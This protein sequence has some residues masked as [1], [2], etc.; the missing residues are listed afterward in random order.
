MDALGPLLEKAGTSQKSEVVVAADVLLQSAP[1]AETGEPDKPSE[2]EVESKSSPKVTIVTEIEEEMTEDKPPPKPPTPLPS[3]DGILMNEEIAN[4]V[5]PVFQASIATKR[6]ALAEVVLDCLQLMIAH[7]CI[8]GVVTTV[9]TSLKPELSGSGY[10]EGLTK[11]PGRVPY[12]GQIIDMICQCED[13][14]E[15]GVEL[16]VLKALLTAVTS[17]TFC[18]HGHG[19]LLAV[20]TSYNIYLMSR[21]P[22][23]QTTAKA[24]L[25]QMLNVVFQ[26]ME[27]NSQHI[28]VSPIIVKDVIDP[29]PAPGSVDPS[30]VQTFLNKV[31]AETLFA[32][33]L[34]DLRQSVAGAFDR[35]HD[36]EGMDTSTDSDQEHIEWRKSEAIAV[37]SVK[38]PEQQPI[39]PIVETGPSRP[40]ER[41]ASAESDIRSSVL[42]K[43]AY[44]VF[45]AL[46]KLSTTSENTALDQA[47]IRGKV[48]ALELIKILLEN[49]GP[50]FH[51]S[52]KFISALKDNLCL[53]MLKNCSSSIQ[54]VLSLTCSIFL[55][56]L[57]K[58]RRSLKAEI[59]V[60][61]PMVVLKPIEPQVGGGSTTTTTPPSSTSTSTSYPHQVK[62]EF[63]DRIQRIVGAC[64]EASPAVLFGGTIAD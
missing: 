8:R 32:P 64:S 41:T 22:V 24:S 31:V 59:A 15:E 55:T 57:T 26:R 44:L 21:S 52:E 56:L 53:S 17:S 2:P 28:T 9:G 40:P 14:L 62:H 50:V 7:R 42:Q 4:A 25:T 38:P 45:R 5:F 34:D 16:K 47:A 1:E 30:T 11:E 13:I 18:I 61:F 19:L 51:G 33:S 20:R 43:D 58:F 60:F 36:L 10:V 27:S 54:E 46:C 29:G 39:A 37:S 12:Q 23:N 63:M 48:L 3:K 49:S 35:K 6:G